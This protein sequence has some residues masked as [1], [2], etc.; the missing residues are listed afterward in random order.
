[1]KEKFH[2]VGSTEVERTRSLHLLERKYQESGGWKG[3]ILLLQFL[4]CLLG[5]SKTSLALQFLFFVEG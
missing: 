1:M 3:S 5:A 2:R 4:I